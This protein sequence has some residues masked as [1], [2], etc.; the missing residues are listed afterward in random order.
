MFGLGWTEMLVIGIVALIV[1]GPED[2]PQMFRTMGKF[3]GKARGMAREFSRAMNDAA[4]QAGVNEINKSIKAAANPAKFST[5]QLRKAAGFG[6]ETQKL[7]EE[8]E[9]TRRKVS[10]YT[11]KKAEERL[12]RE[13]AQAEADEDE[14]VAAE[15]AESAEAE[16]E[17][18]PR[19]QP[20]QSETSKS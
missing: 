10:E 5:D 6:P 3:T 9:E 1:V 7:S 2:L 12:A 8:R 17:A 11:A 20:E 13:A 15:L 14:A 4:D 19:P 16:A 18:T